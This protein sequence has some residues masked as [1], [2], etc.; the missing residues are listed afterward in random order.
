MIG[1]YHNA[2]FTFDISSFFISEGILVR[3]SH[4]VHVSHC[5]YLVATTMEDIH[6]ANSGVPK[7]RSNKNCLD[8][9]LIG[10]FFGDRER[11]LS[12]LPADLVEVGDLSVHDSSSGLNVCPI[13]TSAIS[14]VNKRKHSIFFSRGIR[15]VPRH[16]PFLAPRWLLLR[17]RTP[18]CRSVSLHCPRLTSTLRSPDTSNSTHCSHVQ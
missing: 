10:T 6:G 14:M 3:F 2:A 13:L 9:E 16:G 17:R 11:R 8:A 18:F 15:T 4:A 5:Y 7:G 1:E 12:V